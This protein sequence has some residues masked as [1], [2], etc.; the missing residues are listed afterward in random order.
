MV[1]WPSPQLSSV[2]VKKRGRGNGYKGCNRSNKYM[3]L[4]V[5]KREVGLMEND[6]LQREEEEERKQKSFLNLNLRR[7]GDCPS[8]K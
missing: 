5:N 6:K 3:A 7:R 4:L 2:A 8:L 1:F